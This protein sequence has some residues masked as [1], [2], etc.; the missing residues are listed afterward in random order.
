MTTAAMPAPRQHRGVL[1]RLLS[2]FTEVHPGEGLTALV[3]MLNAFLLLAAYY[4]LKPLR[5]G[6]I[7]SEAHGAEIKSYAAAGMAVLLMVLVPAY[8]ALASRVDRVRLISWVTVFFVS[9]LVIFFV[10]LRAGVPHLG[11]AF[12]LWIGIFNLMVVAQFWAFA[13]DVY[14]PGQGRRLFGI[15]GFGSSMGA[16]AGGLAAKPLIDRMGTQVPMLVAAGVLALTIVLTRIVNTREHVAHDVGGRPVDERAPLSAR[17]AFRLVFSERYLLL[18]AAL[19]LVYN[20]VNTNGEYILGKTVKAYVESHVVISPG[21]NADEAVKKGIDEFYAGFYTWV[22]WIGAAIQLLLV[23][24]ILKRFGP[25]IALF[26]L[27]LISLGGYGMI[28]TAALSPALV[29]LIRKV[30]IAE[31]ATDYSLYTTTRQAL[32]LPTSRDAKYKA[33]AAIDTFFVRFGDVLSAGLVLL[34]TTLAL[35]PRSFAA[36]NIGLIVLWLLLVVAIGI[37][38]QRLEHARG[39]TPGTSGA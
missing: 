28:A 29:G 34:G 20:A 3:L 1:D 14:A 33:K 38:Y 10:L 25:R 11:V 8:G 18:I 6:L 21:A 24:R 5:E 19:V 30:K 13:N 16:I 4:I 32:F 26:V 15:V 37:R 39:E 27:P 35:T 9:N 22:N 12:F 31:N 17:G 2:P 36:V 23:G 7:L